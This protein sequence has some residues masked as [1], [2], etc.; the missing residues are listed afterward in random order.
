MS[1]RNGGTP[2][3]A[4]NALEPNAADALVA[5]RH[6]DPFAILGPHY[7]PG[8]QGEVRVF[9]PHAS[10]VE[11][12]SRDGAVAPLEN[13]HDGGL[14][15]GPLPSAPGEPYRLR[16]RAGDKQWEEDDPYRFGHILG[17]LDLHLIA[18]GQ[19]LRIYEKLGA[20]IITRDSTS[21]V[22]FAVWAPGA[23]RVS[24]VGDFNGWD[25]RRHPMRKRHEAG[26]WELFVP[27]MTAGDKYKFE[28][29]DGDGNLL[30]LKA[31]PFA[32]RQ[33]PPPGNASII[34]H[35]GENCIIGDE[36]QKKR[37]QSHALD[38]P[39]SIYE[40]HLGSWRRKTG[41][42]YLSYDELADALVPYAL[43]LGFTHIELMPVS[44]YPFDGSW[45][46]QPVG[47][48]AP[49]SRFGSPEAFGRFVRRCHDAGL[50]VFVDW[51]AGHFPT[52]PHGLARFDGT[53]LYEHE[54]PRLGFHADWNTLIYNYGRNEVANY[55]HANAL[56]W[57]ETFGIDGLRVDAVASMLYLDYSRKQGEWI[58]NAFG[59][60]ENLEAVAFLRRLNE[61][62]FGEHPGTTTIAEESTS[63]P[64]VSRPTYLG[65]LGFGYKW[66]MGWMNDTLEYMRQDPVHRK[67]HHSKLTFGLVY[68]FSENFILPL[69]HDEVV[70]GKGSLLEKMPG[71]RWQKFANL[72]A[73]LGFMWAHPGKKLLFMGGE[74]GQSREWNHDRSLDW[75]ELDD[76][77]HSGVQT[78]VRDLNMLYRATPALYQK[79]VDTEGFQW[80]VMND[81][82]ASVFAFLRLGLEG[83]PPVLAVSNFTPI[84]RSSYRLGVPQAGRW[85][86][87]LNTDATVYGGAGSGNLGGVKTDSLPW[88]I[89]AQSVSLTIPPLAT[90]FFVY[91]GDANAY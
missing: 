74:F 89:H 17:D 32:F 87:V 34:Q 28:I 84:S 49:T 82:E 72:R 60:R 61:I 12:I 88:G 36:W 9:A 53:A 46:Y 2:T 31:D 83:E 44:E 10:S 1:S 47:L 42:K 14:F 91:E 50:G 23:M 78:L 41:N 58:P 75:H 22:S 90:M 76:S 73:Y 19:H 65:G 38:G 85:R 20:H 67:Y 77:L 13:I 45:G 26:V 8:G 16:L 51:V 15:A 43:D 33:E 5:G 39:V 57:M 24:V 79:D 80:V 29:L 81:V 64:A 62:N 18:E 11:I 70:H 71:D 69:S 25:G 40:V 66:N 6:G 52:D 4:K 63:W 21:G 86:E 30:P 27:R 55:L 3:R 7:P 35:P 56:Y 59:G 68:A 48:Y 37:S 54:D